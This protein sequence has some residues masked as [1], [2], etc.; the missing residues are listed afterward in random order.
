MFLSTPRS[1]M[2][3]CA[4]ALSGALLAYPATGQAQDRGQA[5]IDEQALRQDMQRAIDQRRRE[6]LPEYQR[7]V[8]TE[9]RANADAWLRATAERLGRE[10]G[11]RVR[12]RHASGAYAAPVAA[13]AP[14]QPAQGTAPV[15]DGKGKGTDPACARM[16]TRQRNVPSVSGGPMQMIMVTECVPAR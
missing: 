12:R 13:D 4:I 10:D 2:L 1:L 15:R 6:L 11:E 3:G 9:G 14:R 16:V 7:R 8:R 5:A